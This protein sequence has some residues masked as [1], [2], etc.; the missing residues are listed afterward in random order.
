MKKPNLHIEDENVD[1]I[2]LEKHLEMNNEIDIMLK[3]ERKKL[4][5]TIYNIKV[6]KIADALSDILTFD[7]EH[8][9]FDVIKD[10]AAVCLVRNGPFKYEGENSN[11]ENNISLWDGK[12]DYCSCGKTLMDWYSKCT[13]DKNDIMTIMVDGYID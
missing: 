6:E 2:I 11:C 8:Q 10:A 12:S 5:Q 9:Q 13:D 7:L 4:K 1:L 3:K